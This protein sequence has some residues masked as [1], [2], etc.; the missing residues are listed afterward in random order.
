MKIW[1]AV[2]LGVT[3][4][5]ILSGL[6]IL[7]GSPPRG[8]PIEL[9]PSSTPKSIAVH[10]TGAINQPGVYYLP[11]DS[12]LI[13]LVQAAGGL[14]ENADM[15][16]INLAAILRDGQKIYI[17]SKNEVK[18]TPP[19]TT[20]PPTFSQDGKHNVNINLASMDELMTL[21]GIGESKAQA[22]IEYRS[23]NGAFKN[24]ADIQRVPGIGMVIFEKIKDFISID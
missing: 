7:I 17:S 11:I 12:R 15:E 18:P 8:S 14:H 9:M 16:S 24:I 19:V 2:T 10:I 23:K 3:F 6:I 22:I 5:F 20:I 13:Q 4:G 21:P 1:Q